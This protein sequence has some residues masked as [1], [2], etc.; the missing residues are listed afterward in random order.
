[1]GATTRGAPSGQGAIHGC[2]PAEPLSDRRRR[3]RTATPRPAGA[4]PDAGPLSDADRCVRL[5][6]V[7]PTGARHLR[8]AVRASD[9]G[10]PGARLLHAA[11]WLSAGLLPQP[12]PDV[13]LR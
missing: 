11:A 13:R 12:R 6:Q 1:M 9:E 5:R 7:I 4:D 3:P 2:L 10:L 8:G